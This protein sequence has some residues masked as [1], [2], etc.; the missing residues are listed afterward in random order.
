MLDKK[1]TNRKVDEMPIN[2]SKDYLWRYIKDKTLD[3]SAT[4]NPINIMSKKFAYSGVIATVLLV[5]IIFSLNFPGNIETVHA[6]F[7]MTAN[8]EAADGVA[9]DSSFT[10]LASEDLSE[11]T[12][13]ENLKIS[14]EVEF[15]VN[16]MSERKFQI[17]PAE[18][19]EGNTVYNFTI[20]S[21]EGDFSW[22]Y[23]V[24]DTFKISGSIPGDR[25]TSVPTDSGIE[26]NFSHENFDFDNI[27][28]YFE[29]APP[30]KGAFEKHQRTV[31]FVPKDGLKQATIYTITLKAGLE[32]KGTDQK[33]ANDYVFKFETKD[34]DE[35]T[36]PTAG[37][38]QSYYEVKPGNTMAL[39][40]YAYENENS[41]AIQSIN[42]EVYKYKDVDQYLK[43]LEDRFEIPEWSYRTKDLYKYDFSSLSK[44]G[45]FEALIDSINW[46]K[47]MYLPDQEFSA[48]YYLFQFENG[49]KYQQA[50]V[51]VSDVSSYLNISLSDSL[52]WAND[53]KTGKAINGATVELSDGKSYKTDESGIA[54]FTTPERWK[55]EFELRSFD[56]VKITSPDGKVL[57]N[58]IN[59]YNSG[60]EGYNYWLSFATD[61]PIY[62][63]TDS[64]N[65][66]GVMKPKI[67]DTEIKNV[68]LKV[69][70]DWNKF[71]KE[72]PLKMEDDFTF[73][74]KIDI[75][76]YLPGY[77][78]ASLLN[79]GE[80]VQSYSFQVQDYIK[81]AYNLS[82]ESNKK[83]VFA[84][85]KVDFNI[86]S[87]FFDGTVF[88]GLEVE[89][90]YPNA[91]GAK[92]STDQNGEA[93]ISVTAEKE[94]CYEYCYDQHGLYFE[95][96]ASLAEESNIW[97]SSNVRVFDSH[98]NLAAHGV[99]ENSKGSIEISTN[100]IDLSKLN[101]ED[102][103][104]YADF[105]G[106]KA[107]GREVNGE[108]TEIYW[109]KVEEGEHYDFI[110]KKV[111]KDYRY[112]KRENSIGTFKVTTDNDGKA[113]Y[114]FDVEAKKFYKISLTSN[115]DQGN[116]A[117]ASSYVYGKEG[118][119]SDYDYYNIKILNVNETD[120]KFDIGE[121]VE[122]AFL[123]DDVPVEASGKFLFMQ[124]SAGLK[125]YEIQNSAYYNFEFGKEDV[126]NVYLSGVWFDGE[127]YESTAV[128]SVDYK[129]ELKK[130]NVEVKTDKSSYKPGEEVTLD[131]KVTDINGSPVA[132][133]V[134]FNLVDE[135]YYK[136]IYDNF[137]DP[138]N[139]LYSNNTDGILES[140]DS[141]E[142]P[143]SAKSDESGMGGCFTGE[144]KIL[145]A[146]GS[147]K[148][149]KDIN[150]GDMILTKKHPYSSELVAAEVLNTV[151]HFVSEYYVINE[152]LEATGVHTVFVNGKWQVVSNIKVGD[153][154]LGEHGEEIIVDS[155]RKVT[156]PI[157]VYNFE[158]KDKHTYFAD[159]YYVHNDKGG[160]NIRDDFEDTALFDVV[161]TGGNGKGS[162]SF[163][164]PDN[165]TSW[166]V[167][168]KAIDTN[169]LQAGAVVANVKVS[170]PF[171]A[172]LIINREY[173]VQDIPMI[174]FRAFGDDLKKG[175]K[176]TFKV[177]GSAVEGEAFKGSYFEL[178][179]LKEGEQKVILNAQSGSMKDALSKTID[180]RS[181]RLK[182]DISEFMRNV[183]ANTTFKL[184]K[185]GATQIR[186]MDGGVGFYYQNLLS[187]YNTDGERLDQK[188]SRLTA[189]DLMKRYFN[190]E[191]NL[192]E[193]DIVANY[194]KNGLKLLPYGDEDLRITALALYVDTTPGRYDTNHLK[195][196]FYGF[197]VNPETNLEDLV[198]S[199]LGLASIDEPVLLSLREIQNDENLSIEQKLYIAL[200]FESLGSKN[201]AE[202]IYN[203]VFSKLA[204]DYDSAYATALGAM[205]AAGLNEDEAATLLR[206][207]AAI[208]GIKDDIN[209]L[210]EIGYL[211]NSLAHARPGTS[212]IKVKVNN[213]VEEKELKA[214]D[215]YELVAFPGDEVSVS[216]EE[217]AVSALSYYGKAIAAADFEGQISLGIDRHYFVN[218]VE[219]N[220][221]KEGD[222]IEVVLTPS[223]PTGKL[224]NY[225][226]TDILPSGLTP[227]SNTKYFGPYFLLDY[228]DYGDR[229]IRNP[230]RVNKQEVYFHLYGYGENGFFSYPQIKYFARVV[231]PGK[232]YAEPAKIQSYLDVKF[233]NISEED[234][235]TIAPLQ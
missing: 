8:E 196:Y 124:F 12:I 131:V 146:D 178:D 212:K 230:Y 93:N 191:N 104:A 174:K 94:T 149:I 73:S 169:K 82:V 62:K 4:N 43:A 125:D 177:D 183:D 156:E 79:D 153:V 95:V 207:F 57:V 204:T 44:V 202:K 109:E 64:V 181:S 105:L 214:G 182:E 20:S 167:T 53:L 84:G 96:N 126:P 39:D 179:K 74:G 47:Y 100:W 52:I 234:K 9:T 1:F 203:E 229:T 148:A 90:S 195:D 99:S 155:I 85:E 194:Q 220:N 232:F 91:D 215:S 213:N 103:I 31:S 138:L 33:L 114:S 60:Y 163:K 46:R 32:L 137:N 224:E 208:T 14:P 136:I 17:E 130:L 216:V 48:G 159:G 123:N 54:K 165:I 150:K 184:A 51:Q 11:A 227:V 133:A 5:A 70:Y 24:K 173:S 38:L 28:K 30:T 68:T 209:N 18:D 2:K 225:L 34:D 86:N 71:L 37:F 111:V 210:Y 161:H 49:G 29:I 106:E 102:E 119:S 235:I 186:L 87:K 75:Q 13:A 23:Q 211:K 141:H 201:E 127:K 22:A 157:W 152:N 187:L 81:P 27:D 76:N 140:Y 19:L 78:T 193:E 129:N 66:W 45:T 134:N 147:S 143:L 77:Y 162:I 142:N 139:E 92:I 171:F 21:S 221:F 192:V 172:D 61:R 65:F 188:L 101:D 218:G 180:V 80:F 16:K 231:N 35:N 72:I 40:I 42:V 176:V 15:K 175:D 116:A 222:L 144:T 58:N 25:A 185:E 98:I 118:K 189:A 145:M 120:H 206:D 200:A 107:K 199:L 164:L 122:S 89:Y 128:T 166:R 223:V 26:I 190:Q 135:A 69:E 3:K 217:G 112:D 132:A 88:P 108:I 121:K 97:E 41:A 219:T 67:S 113:Q 160:D 170:L 115:D 117:H 226:L 158:V 154:M 56:Y 55:K 7:E 198:L 197:Y 228:G 205:L 10:L 83:A 36:Y 151:S 6:S 59:P 168:A 110:N 233:S 50:L 63:P